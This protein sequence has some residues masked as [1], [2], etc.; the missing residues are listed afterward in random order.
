MK[1]FPIA[2]VLLV[3]GLASLPPGASGQDVPDCQ[4]RLDRSRLVS[5][6]VIAGRTTQYV[7]HGVWS[8]LGRPGTAGA[9]T[10]VWRAQSDSVVRFVA[11]GR[12]EFIEN[13]DFSDS[14][15]R[16]TADRATYFER[17]D[18]LEARG[19][20][21]LVNSIT[22]TVLSGPQ[23]TYLREVQGVRDTAELR[24]TRRP[25]VEYRAEG[26]TTEPY[27]IVADRVRLRGNATWA[28]GQVTIDRSDFA[29]RGD[30]AWLD[31]GEGHGVI[32]GNA[33]ASGQDTLGYDL[34]G[35]RLAFGLVD[36]KLNWVQAE[37][38]AR[39]TSADWEIVGDTIMFSVLNDLIQAGAAWGD[40]TR[41]LAT[42]Q[43]YAIGADSL[44]V[45][46]PDQ[47]LEEVRGYGNALATT[48]SDSSG[49]DP[50]WMAGDTV[51][52]RFYG[53][54][55]GGRALAQLT[56]AGNARAFYKI[57]DEAD[58]TGA[59]AINYSRG[60]R[61]VA[62]F[63]DDTVDRVDVIGKADGVYLEPT[64]KPPR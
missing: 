63:K 32:V 21:R 1:R 42:S 52:A 41:P 2:G 18:S 14:T 44:A 48:S 40:S 45:D 38:S 10:I 8:C 24:A 64:K 56:A 33:E 57:I 36:D 25:T 5:Q 15:A 51:T 12:I 53:T 20:V 60:L 46:T 16:L 27:V 29:G 28:V 62:A 7:S 43:A 3:G 19:H 34:R 31:L 59:P 23:L 9:G 55:T 50:D 22:G 26:D 47:E 37:G 35:E 58:S 49:S 30:S 13:V 4:V 11:P 6:K 54:E 39:A 17:Y 61:I